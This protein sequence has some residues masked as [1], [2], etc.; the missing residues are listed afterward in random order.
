MGDK[1]VLMF[2]HFLYGHLTWGLASLLLL[3][4]CGLHVCHL[5]SLSLL[6]L[7]WMCLVTGV[8]LDHRKCLVNARG[9]GDAHSHTTNGQSRPEPV[10]PQC[11]PTSE[12]RGS[13]LFLW[14]TCQFTLS[15]SGYVLTLGAS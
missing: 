8:T 11:V 1:L 15:R 5:S 10:F 14:E 9:D 12:R 13:R 7:P 2:H 3:R 4:V 6:P